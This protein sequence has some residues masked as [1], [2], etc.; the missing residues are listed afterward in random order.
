M[1]RSRDKTGEE[2]TTKTQHTGAHAWM[3]DACKADLSHRCD[4]TPLCI[5][6]AARSVLST[7][8]CARPMRATVFMLFIAFGSSMMLCA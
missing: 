5:Q 1:G 3:D 6:W 4:V 7:A 2:K 8:C